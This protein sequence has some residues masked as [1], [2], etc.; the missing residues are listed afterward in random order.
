MRM[1]IGLIGHKAQGMAITKDEPFEK[2]LLHFST[3]ATK[4]KTSGLEYTMTVC[5]KTLPDFVIGNKV[6]DL[7]RNTLLKIGTS[8]TDVQH[9]LF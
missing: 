2:A 3:S 1:V 4:N 8:P 5:A 9:R 7:D 6:A